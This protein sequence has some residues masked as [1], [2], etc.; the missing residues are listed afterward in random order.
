MKSYEFLNIL[1]AH[2]Q[3]T[4]TQAQRIIIEKLKVI[5]PVIEDPETFL[6]LATSERTN[7]PMYEFGFNG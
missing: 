1:Q 2:C 3:S 7:L 5:K 6:D 4:A